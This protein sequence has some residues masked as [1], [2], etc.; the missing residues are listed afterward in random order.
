LLGLAN[1]YVAAWIEPCT[2][3]SIAAEY[4]KAATL[5]RAQTM[6]RKALEYD[7]GLAEA[8][9]ALG[10]VLHQQHRRAEGLKQYE[11]AFSLNP[12]LAD[13]RYGI[14][15]CLEGRTAQGIEFSST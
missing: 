13:G 4:G 14:V 3:P 7:S 2:L 6:V 8:H 9:A 5:E 1:T 11:R 15:L 12:N 10:Y